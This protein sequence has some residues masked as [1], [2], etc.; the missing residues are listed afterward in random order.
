MINNSVGTLRTKCL[1]YKNLFK[2]TAV[3][4]ENHIKP[5][6]TVGEIQEAHKNVMFKEA[7]SEFWY[8]HQMTK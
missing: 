2:K 1:Q 5:I 8:D 4:S 6:Y 7:Y 3:Y